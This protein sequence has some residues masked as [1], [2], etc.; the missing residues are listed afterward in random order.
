MKAFCPVCY[1]EAK[2]DNATSEKNCK[3][4]SIGV[5]I[6][7]DGKLITFHSTFEMY[8]AESTDKKRNTIRFN[9][10]GWPESMKERFWG[11]THVRIFKA[12]T[13]TCFIR[14]IIHKTVFNNAAIISW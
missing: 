12:Y 14:E 7:E 13:S 6:I 3:C 2:C 8:D 11:S 10:D 4:A 1:K 9:F 5:I